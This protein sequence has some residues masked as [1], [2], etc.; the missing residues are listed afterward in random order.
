MC[1][2]AGVI[3]W[4][5]G[6]KRGFTEHCREDSVLLLHQPRYIYN[7]HILCDDVVNKKYLKNPYYK[8]MTKKEM[9][10][11]KNLYFHTIGDLLNVDSEK[12]KKEAGTKDWIVSE[13]E[14]IKK[15][16]C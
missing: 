6:R 8:K 1:A 13:Q 7:Q 9:E 11:V 16:W 2:S 14:A 10:H 5:C 12:L 15:G 4:A 3:L